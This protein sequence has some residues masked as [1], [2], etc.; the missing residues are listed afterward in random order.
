MLWEG[1]G[2]QFAAV[3]HGDMACRTLTPE[4]VGRRIFGV[5]IAHD[6][7]IGQK[8]QDRGAEDKPNVEEEQRRIVVLHRGRVGAIVAMNLERPRLLANCRG[9]IIGHLFNAPENA[10]GA[11]GVVLKIPQHF[12]E[13][14]R[15][16]FELFAGL[17]AAPQM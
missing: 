6:L 16:Y 14:D 15:P 2:E 7:A 1:G 13:L 8:S 10:G 3:T 12:R 4:D 9:K 17:Y 11:A 5:S